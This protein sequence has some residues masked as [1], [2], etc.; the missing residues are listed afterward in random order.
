MLYAF[1]PQ[2]F[3]VHKTK[4][5]SKRWHE[6]QEGW[7]KYM[8]CLHM[9]T[10]ESCHAKTGSKKIPSRHGL[11][12]PCHTPRLLAELPAAHWAM[13]PATAH[14]VGILTEM[15]LRCHSV[16]C[17]CTP[18]YSAYTLCALPGH[19]SCTPSSSSCACSQL[20]TT[21]CFV[22]S[23]RFVLAS[24][25]SSVKIEMHWL[26]SSRLPQEASL[27]TIN[28]SKHIQRYVYDQ[29]MFGKGSTINHLG[30]WYECIS[31]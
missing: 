11:D 15:Y 7:V 1:K 31:T 20:F 12:I 21:S 23:F 30:A 17:R 19:C 27:A 13:G 18:L 6:L 22:S 26:L 3:G 10:S 25:G 5:Q 24:Q 2:E 29:R 28:I 4:A 9:N 8:H 14:G 16:Y